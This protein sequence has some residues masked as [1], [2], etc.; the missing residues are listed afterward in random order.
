MQCNIVTWFGWLVVPCD[1]YGIVLK[2]GLGVV[3]NS[4]ANLELLLI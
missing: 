4:N 2:M 1:Q 3:P